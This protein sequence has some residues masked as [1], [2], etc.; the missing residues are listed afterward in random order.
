MTTQTPTLPRTI[1]ETFATGVAVDHWTQ[2]NHDV[3]EIITNETLKDLNLDPNSSTLDIPANTP[4]KTKMFRCKDP[5]CTRIKC[6][7]PTQAKLSSAITRV[8]RA[9]GPYSLML[10]I[11]RLTDTELPKAYN[12]THHL[13][14]HLDTLDG[15]KCAGRIAIGEYHNSGITQEAATKAINTKDRT[16]YPYHLHIIIPIAI[17]PPTSPTQVET[18]ANT[19]IRARL[20]KTLYKGTLPMA[21][22]TQEIAAIT[23]KQK[24]SSIPYASIMHIDELAQKKGH[25]DYLYDY[26]TK[27]MVPK[28]HPKLKNPTAGIK[29]HLEINDLLVGGQGIWYRCSAS[30]FTIGDFQKNNKYRDLV[31]DNNKRRTMNFKVKASHKGITRTHRVTAAD[32]T[33]Y[34]TLSAQKARTAIWKDTYNRLKQECITEYQRQQAREAS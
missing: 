3:Y 5:R 28:G 23:A 10:T 26:L 31:S 21:D 20:D 12:T 14:K 6:V 11:P 22:M 19:Y 8:V 2:D 13:I 30:F 7:K 33:Q 25:H 18:A 34:P 27:G 16:Q 4:T 24:T 32:F 29:R 1:I 15:V 9:K 17:E